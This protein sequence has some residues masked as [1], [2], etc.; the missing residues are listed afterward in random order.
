M[1]K[2]LFFAQL[3]ELLQCSQLNV[4]LA[5]PCDI[6]TL[7]QHLIN[8]HP[9]WEVHLNT[10]KVLSA[11]NQKMVDVNHSVKHGDEVAFFPPVTGG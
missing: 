4:E 11:V 8:E 1:I 9:D 10:N 7:K 6:Q 3:K 2:V 5:T